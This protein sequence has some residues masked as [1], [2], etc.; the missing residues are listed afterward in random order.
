LGMFFF[1]FFLLFSC[2][3]FRFKKYWSFLDF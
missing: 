3:F 2:V 1:L